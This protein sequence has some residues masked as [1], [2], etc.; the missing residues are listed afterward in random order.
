M[1]AALRRAAAAAARLPWAPR[2]VAAAPR[3]AAAG[4]G[5]AAAAWAAPVGAR[6]AAAAASGS[7]S[8][9]GGGATLSGVAKAR[10]AKAKRSAKAKPVAALVRVRPGPRFH[11]EEAV[12]ILRATTTHGT[13]FDQTIDLLVQ[14]GID[15]RK[16]NMPVRG[17]AALP[18]GTGK[19]V[20]IAVFARGD[21]AAEARAAGATLVGAEDLV[22]RIA[23]GE[24]GFDRA[25]ATPDM[26]PLV[27][28]VARVRER[29]RGWWGVVG[30]GWGGVGGRRGWAG[31]GAG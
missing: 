1:E 7:G 26:M 28:K 9:G 5:G 31:A 2:A 21:K 27:G 22:D 25:I 17:V 29:T 23:K 11:V 4:A 30:V 20:A 19:T 6:G 16:T 14:L 15:P 12:R 13:P 18:H 10:L 8:G 24:L 3:W